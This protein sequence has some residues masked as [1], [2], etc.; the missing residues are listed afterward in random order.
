MTSPTPDPLATQITRARR[1][2]SFWST[3][4]RRHV[5]DVKFI[6]VWRLANDLFAAL[7]AADERLALVD[8]EYTVVVAAGD[9]CSGATAPTDQFPPDAAVE[10]LDTALMHLSMLSRANRAA[11]IRK[12][13]ATA[14]PVMLAA[15]IDGLDSDSM[16]E[17]MRRMHRAW[18]ADTDFSECVAAWRAALTR[19]GGAPE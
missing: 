9:G 13:A 6:D 7:K 16:Y 18:Q 17:M 14:F 12:A 15:W 4:V 3:E 8:P 5:E 1:E 2:F 19:L 10:M 11:I